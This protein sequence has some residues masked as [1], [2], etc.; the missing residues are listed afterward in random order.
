MDEQ[1][2]E[3]GS[4][5]VG[6]V[7]NRPET[8]RSL[9]GLVRV[10]SDQANRARGFLPIDEDPRWTVVIEGARSLLGVI[11]N[12]PGDEEVKTR[13]EE[14]DR[15]RRDDIAGF[16]RVKE[17]TDIS[18]IDKEV[19][20]FELA[21]EVLRQEGFNMALRAVGFA[22]DSNGLLVPSGARF[23]EDQQREA[24]SGFNDHLPGIMRRT[25]GEE[26]FDTGEED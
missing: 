5:N 20:R 10:M 7:F 18:D 1:Q 11:S 12:S 22:I 6:E 13:I 14:I 23:S 21:R 8:G 15:R 16:G 24:V 17:R 19:A 26:N 9:I 25:Y 3:Q 2:L 4:V